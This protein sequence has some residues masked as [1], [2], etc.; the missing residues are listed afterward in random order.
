MGSDSANVLTVGVEVLEDR[1]RDGRCSRS[2]SGREELRSVLSAAGGGRRGD[3]VG[4]GFGA[5]FSSEVSASSRLSLF[6]PLL[7]VLRS[8]R[9]APFIPFTPF[10][11]LA[12]PSS[13]SRSP[14]GF[15]DSFIVLL[16]ASF[17]LPVV[18]DTL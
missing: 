14:L 1:A 7:L 9:T 10:I 3:A 13:M 4:M 18:A 15:T 6:A 2:R 16:I 12:D 17:V 11:D 8:S 5:R